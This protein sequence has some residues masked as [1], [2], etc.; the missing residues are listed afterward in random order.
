M[1]GMGEKLGVIDQFRGTKEDPAT[2]QK[3]E[4]LKTKIRLSSEWC[5]ILMG[6]H[7]NT[8]QPEGKSAKCHHLVKGCLVERELHSFDIWMNQRE[9]QREGSRKANSEQGKSE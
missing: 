3:T 8:S 9:R 7:P 2:E 1:G 4:S 5:H 6:L